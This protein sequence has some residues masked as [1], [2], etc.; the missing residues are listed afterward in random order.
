[1][2]MAS[3]A[4]ILCAYGARGQEI[5]ALPAPYGFGA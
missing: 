2:I 3:A 1:M 4:C 5:A